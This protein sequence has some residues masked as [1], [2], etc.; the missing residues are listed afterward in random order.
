MQVQLGFEAEN[1]FHTK[2]LHVSLKGMAIDRR[3]VM[4]PRWYDACVSFPARI[5][6]NLNLLPV[7]C[8][9]EQPH[10]LTGKIGTPAP[11]T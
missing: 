5:S 7:Y 10:F 11:E 9:P 8:T 4:V 3:S 1:D 2:V 6:S